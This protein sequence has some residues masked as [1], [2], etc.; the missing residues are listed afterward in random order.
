MRSRTR[1]ALAATR[2]PRRRPARSPA[3]PRAGERRRVGSRDAEVDGAGLGGGMPVASAR[4][5][6]GAI[7]YPRS[8]CGL[9][10]PHLTQNL[11]RFL[12]TGFDRQ[13]ASHIRNRRVDLRT[14]RTSPSVF[15]GTAATRRPLG[16]PL[17]LRR[18]LVPGFASSA[19]VRR[20]G[21]RTQ[22]T[23]HSCGTGLSKCW[24]DVAD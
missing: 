21:T 22:L 16:K 17:H 6:S 14:D 5:Y 11:S 18:R 23:D 4:Q 1:R 2:P 19:A 20:H 9:T 13:I 15:L 24:A 8:G 3:R 10:T 12:I 7:P